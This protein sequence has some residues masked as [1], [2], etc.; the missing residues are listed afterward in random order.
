MKEAA[1]H[2]VKLDAQVMATIGL[3][4]MGAG[5]LLFIPAT[6]VGMFAAPR[7]REAVFIPVLDCLDDAIVLP[8]SMLIFGCRTPLSAPHQNN[9]C[10]HKGS[11]HGLCF[12]Q[13]FS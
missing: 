3:L 13:L 8:L 2:A 12:R 5:C 1:A 6:Q 7:W 11:D 10:V 9:K 4:T